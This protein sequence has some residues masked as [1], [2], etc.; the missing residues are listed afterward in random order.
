MIGI[1]LNLQ[2]EQRGDGAHNTNDVSFFVFAGRY[3]YIHMCACVYLGPWL[4]RQDGV[5]VHNT[6]VYCTHTRH[7]Y[8]DIIRLSIWNNSSWSQI[9]RYMMRM[10]SA[11]YV[12]TYFTC[13]M[14]LIGH[15]YIWCTLSLSVEDDWK[16]GEKIHENCNLILSLKLRAAFYMSI[17]CTLD[18]RAC[19]RIH[20]F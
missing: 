16:K 12:R 11:Q 18:Y 15:V 7:S 20:F 19:V 1:C 10:R 13:W 14:P 4:R 17:L 6:A 2:C 5:H 3:T 9:R 8:K